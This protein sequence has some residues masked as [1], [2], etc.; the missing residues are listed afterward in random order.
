MQ[1]KQLIVKPNRNLRRNL[2]NLP[3]SFFVSLIDTNHDFK[4]MLCLKITTPFHSRNIMRYCSINEFSSQ[5][6][7]IEVSFLLLR[8]LNIS[9]NAYLKRE[10]LTRKEIEPL[11]TQKRS[12]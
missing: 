8:Q 5:Q 9:Y 3:E 10:G 2:I 6:D 7:C 12:L 11:G 4:D 1:I